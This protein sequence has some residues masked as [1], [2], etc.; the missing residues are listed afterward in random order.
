MTAPYI[1]ADAADDQAMLN[2]LKR[3]EA[4]EIDAVAFTSTP[5]VERLFS[6]ARS[7]TA[8]K[9]VADTVAVTVARMRRLAP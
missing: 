5:Q 6:V 4:G 7:E 1:Y 2:L 8:T 9:A 3:F